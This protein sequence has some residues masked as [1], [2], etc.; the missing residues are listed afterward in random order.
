MTC[1]V[2]TFLFT[3]GTVVFT[4]LFSG[5]VLTL[6]V[7]SDTVENVGVVQN[8]HIFT[9]SFDLRSREFQAKL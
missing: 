5:L 6:T 4:E 7:N 8:R 1:G 3:V 2:G 9:E